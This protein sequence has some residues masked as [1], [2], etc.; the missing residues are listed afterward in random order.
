MVVQSVVFKNSVY[1]PK[2]AIEWLNLH[3]F[4]F[5]KIHRTKNFTRF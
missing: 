3:H 2:Q 1:N 5:K 4:V